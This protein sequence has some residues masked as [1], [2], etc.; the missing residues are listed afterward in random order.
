MMEVR[1]TR[2]WQSPASM[3]KF[4]VLVLSCL[5]LLTPSRGQV[6]L[7]KNVEQATEKLAMTFEEIRSRVLGVDELAVRI[8]CRRERVHL[9]CAC[10]CA[11]MWS[12]SEHLRLVAVRVEMLILYRP[13]PFWKVLWTQNSI[14]TRRIVMHTV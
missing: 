5:F 8:A 10:V 9:L 6:D 2:Y 12:R 1:R 11:Y 7:K 3:A 14:S 13:S 4:E